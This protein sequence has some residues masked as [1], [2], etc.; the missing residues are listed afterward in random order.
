MFLKQNFL[1]FFLRIREK[2]NGTCKGNASLKELFYFLFFFWNENLA[3]GTNISFSRQKSDSKAKVSF[4]SKGHD[5]GE[6]RK[7]EKVVVVKSRSLKLSCDPHRIDRKG[8]ISSILTKIIC[9][10]KFEINSFAYKIE[11]F[12]KVEYTTWILKPE[13]VFFNPLVF[14]KFR[15]SQ[16]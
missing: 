8:D 5:L 2:K 4:F 15:E 11:K 13:T 16:K 1:N 14:S 10:E 12:A 6:G 3:K 9:D 7:E